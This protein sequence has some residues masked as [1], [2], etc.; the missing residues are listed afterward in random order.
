MSSKEQ[1]RIALK[2]DKKI[3]ADLKKEIVFKDDIIC[4]Q[5]NNIEYHKVVIEELIK[6]SS[7]KWWQFWK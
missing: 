5:R 2:G 4:K 3:I 6:A 7:K 1:F